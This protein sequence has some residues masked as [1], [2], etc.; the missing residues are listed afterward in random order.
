MTS[1]LG[2]FR[3]VVTGGPD[4]GR[5]P[6]VMSKPSQS[7][8]S[9]GRAVDPERDLI[10]SD[11]HVSR[12]HATIEYSTRGYLLTDRNSTN[13]TW[14]N[15][16]QLEPGEPRELQDGDEVRLGPNTSIRFETVKV[17][18]TRTPAKTPPSRLRHSSRRKA[19][20]PPSEPPP[21]EKPPYPRR[22]D[23]AGTSSTSRSGSVTPT[24]STAPSTRTRGPLWRSNG[25]AAHS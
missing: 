16:C 8:L 6:F 3:I 13:R 11:P 5:E 7:V 18:P 12:R 25:S 23:W 9:M 22:G 14:L 21:A 4:A 2:G 24:G 1:R 15:G 20:H 17:D 19:A 10:L